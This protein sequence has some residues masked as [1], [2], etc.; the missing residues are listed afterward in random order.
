MMEETAMENN[1]MIS[2]SMLR[3]LKNR[4]LAQY[5]VTEAQL[6][7]IV[8]KLFVRDGPMYVLMEQRPQKRQRQ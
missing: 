6:V 4:A 3:E 5:N 1:G 8:D 2:A 7:C